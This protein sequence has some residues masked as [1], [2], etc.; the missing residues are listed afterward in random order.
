MKEK[1]HKSAALFPKVI[2]KVVVNQIVVQVVLVERKHSGQ[3]FTINSCAPLC[4]VQIFK[5]AR[6]KSSVC[7]KSNQSSSSSSNS[8]LASKN[9][10]MTNP[11]KNAK[12]FKPGTVALRE[13]RK[14]QG[15]GKNPG[16]FAT[17][18][19]IRKRPFNRLVREIVQ[20]DLLKEM[21]FTPQAILCLQVRVSNSS[22]AFPTPRCIHPISRNSIEKECL[23]S[24]LLLFQEA[25]ECF[26]VQMMEASN[27]CAI[28]AKRVTIMPKDIQ[29][30]L[31]LKGNVMRT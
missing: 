18:L 10:S 16:K 20:V 27:L 1:T 26:L 22:C 9:I 30:A 4:F 31:Y 13:I 5:M 21:R 14:F 28:H 12:K 6:T 19:L 8:K 24:I 11:P 29:L 3:A 23:S 25:A 7:R 15:A 17:D 2:G